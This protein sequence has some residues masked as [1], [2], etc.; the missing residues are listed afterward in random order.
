MCTSSPQTQRDLMRI[1]ESVFG[2]D[3][4]D[5]VDESMVFDIKFNEQQVLTG[6]KIGNMALLSEMEMAT[7]AL[8]QCFCNLTEQITLDAIQAVHPLMKVVGAALEKLDIKASNIYETYVVEGKVDIYGD[9]GD[10]LDDVGTRARRLMGVLES[11]CD[12]ALEYTGTTISSHLAHL[13]KAIVEM[14]TAKPDEEGCVD[15]RATLDGLDDN[16]SFLAK[17]R[18]LYKRRPQKRLRSSWLI[19]WH[20]LL[21]RGPPPASAE[22]PVPICGEELPVFVSR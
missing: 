3:L 8:A 9:A 21:H 7:H 6:V 15:V 12:D 20:R 16:A 22:N 18:S 13:R 14:M 5:F 1:V 4:I 17:A 11:T 2:S 10:A 19:T